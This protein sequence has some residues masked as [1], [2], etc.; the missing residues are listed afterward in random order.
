MDG[1]VLQHTDGAY[2]SAVSSTSLRVARLGLAGL[3]LAAIGTG[4]WRA[5]QAGFDPVDYLSFFTT[6]TTLIAAALLVLTALHPPDERPHWHDWW[7]GAAAVYLTVTF[8]VVIALLEGRFGWNDWTDF[9]THK[10][11]PVAVVADFLLDP[12]RNRLTLRDALAFALYGVAWLGYTFLRGALSGWYPYP[13]LD[14]TVSSATTV[15]ATAGVIV[16]TGM[17]LGV[18]YVHLARHSLARRQ[19]L[20][21]PAEASD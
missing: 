13:F 14:P 9:V 2:P 4:L 10:L 12:P 11:L 15:A 5:M 20:T 3:A 6:Q 16:V 18:L 17:A 21:R 7:R 19:L 8:V 1:S